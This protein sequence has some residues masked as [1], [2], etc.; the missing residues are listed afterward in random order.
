MITDI[1]NRILEICCEE[2]EVDVEAVKS[3]SRKQDLVF[4]RLSF[5]VICK[6]KLNLSSE[7]IGVVI[8]R[9]DSNIDKL[10]KKAKQNYYFL[11][12][13]ETIRIKCEQET[14]NKRIKNE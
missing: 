3:R 6:E 1:L 12:V 13:F 2:F 14:T 8:N 11:T 4:C 5:I 7:K 10:Y 9:T